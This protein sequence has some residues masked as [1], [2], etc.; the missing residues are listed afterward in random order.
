MTK[1]EEVEF[2]T[3]TKF[4]K[5]VESAVQHLR[6]SHMDAILHLCEEYDIEPEDCRKYVNKVIKE[7]LEA[8]AQALHYF[9]KGNELPI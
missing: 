1:S 6:L 7:K 5:L 4:S 3:K 8:E 9:P 2:M